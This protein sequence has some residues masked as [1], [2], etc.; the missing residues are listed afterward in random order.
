MVS[1][2][3]ITFI[4]L[5]LTSYQNFKISD[6]DTDYTFEL[7]QTSDF[8]NVLVTQTGIRKGDPLSLTALVNI[9]QIFFLISTKSS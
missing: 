6:A 8:A 4:C 9:D 7:S 3:I 2:A 1:V 5:E